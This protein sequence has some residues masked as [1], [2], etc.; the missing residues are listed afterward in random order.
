MILCL[1]QA[2]SLCCSVQSWAE[3]AIPWPS[4]PRGDSAQKTRQDMQPGGN[5][6]LGGSILL[7]ARPL[8][9]DF[10]SHSFSS[11][12]NHH[13]NVLAF[14]ARGQNYQSIFRQLLFQTDQ[15]SFPTWSL[16]Q[17][18][19]PAGFGPPRLRCPHFPH[20]KPALQL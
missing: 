12:S 14:K 9:C 15:T 13:Y 7:G 2:L 6:T 1:S 16:S 11:P 17:F 20:I 19:L 8:F 18:F 5:L 4:C 3:N 10:K